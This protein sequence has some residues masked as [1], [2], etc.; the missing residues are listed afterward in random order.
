MNRI[1]VAFAA[2]TALAGV[3]TAAMAAPSN[4]TAD[5][6]LLVVTWTTGFRHQDTI[7]TPDKDGPAQKIVADI[8]KSSGVF[9]VDYCRNQDDVKKMLTPDGLKK[10]DAVFFVNTTGN[11]GIPDLNAFLDWI[12]EGHGF[13]GCHSAADTYHPKDAENNTGYVDMIGGEFKTHNR[14]CEVTAIVNDTAHPAVS[15]L[16]SSAKFFDEIYLYT[17]NMRD[18]VH[19]LLATDKHP[20]D[21]APDANEPGDYL[22]SWCKRH[23]RGRVFYT[24]LGH[25]PEVWAREDYQKHLLG[26]IKW[27][28]GLERGSGR[29]GNPAAKTP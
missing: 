29:P 14:Q 20:N 27:A 17:Q 25:K 7:G 1:V 26:G 12:K 18:K 11:L 2:M 9:D 3:F 28:L 4:R 21:G 6:H 13:I 23:G 8:G 24:E 5:K 10:Y 16:G 15:H 22:L 19:V